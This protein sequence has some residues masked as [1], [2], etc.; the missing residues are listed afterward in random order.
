MVS[1]V[2][3]ETPGEFSFMLYCILYHMYPRVYYDARLEPSYT[4]PGEWPWAVLI[5]DNGEYVG[6]WTILCSKK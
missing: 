2:V 6:E 1:P 5:F 4:N 3:R